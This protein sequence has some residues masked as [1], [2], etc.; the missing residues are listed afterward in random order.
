MVTNSLN[1]TFFLSHTNPFKPSKNIF[2][3]TNRQVFR[4]C[5]SSEDLYY[6]PFPRELLS[7]VLSK[8]CL[9]LFC[10]VIR[11]SNYN[12][13]ISFLL[14]FHFYSIY[15]YHPWQCN[16]VFDQRNLISSFK[17]NCNVVCLFLCPPECFHTC[18]DDQLKKSFLLFT[19]DGKGERKCIY[20]RCIFE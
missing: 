13:W 1:D 11:S 12:T 10:L 18:L 4:P 20:A 19:K 2:L 16:G 6:S 14:F 5:Y 8:M 3:G 9:S 15:T 7:Q 17:Y